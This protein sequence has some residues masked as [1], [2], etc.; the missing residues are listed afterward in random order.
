MGTTRHH[1]AVFDALERFGMRAAS[2]KAM[3][4]QGSGAPRRLTETARASLSESDRL[5]AH[6]HGRADGRLRYAYAPRFILSCSPRLLRGV[7]ERSA[8][9]GALMHSHVA[10]HAEERREV[11][12]LLGKSDLAALEECGIAGPRA[13]LAHGVQLTAREMRRLASLGTRIV[14]CPSANLKLASGIADVVALRR[15]G[16]VVGLGADGAPCNNKLDALGELRLASLLSKVRRKGARALAPLDALRMLTIDGARCLGWEREI[17][18]L[19]TGKRADLVVVGLDGLHQAPGAD[20]LSA[21]V[22]ASS[23]RDV[24][25]VVVDGRVLVRSGELLG[26]DLGRLRAEARRRAGEVATRAGLMR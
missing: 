18:S 17:G 15:A 1:D 5:R 13:V 26:V 10:E 24:R 16:V 20:P 3:M 21:L 22:Y 4:D 9:S 11:A 8:D 25:H 7:A 14:H 6:W 23:A 2:G 12:R 19:E